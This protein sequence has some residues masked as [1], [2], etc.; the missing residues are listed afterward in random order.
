MA[1]VALITGCAVRIGRAIAQHLADS[2]WDV[3]LHY[4]TSGQAIIDCEN[5]LKRTYPDQ[6]FFT[7]Q[8]DFSDS[9]QTSLLIKLVLDRFGRL[10]LLVNNAS[11]FKA[12]SLKETTTKLFREQLQINTVAPF[13]LIRE[14]ANQ[15][16][17]GQIINIVDS[18]ITSNKSEHLSYSLSKK[19]L[20]ELTKMAALELA[21]KF[22]VNAIAPGAILS[23]AGKD[24]LYLGSQQSD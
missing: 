3:A 12:G 21:P 11:V 18:R 9:E 17:K 16:L 2:G 19:S 24:Q 7:F 5:D 6:R 20:W 8:A 1:R 10:D 14:Y 4:S 22:R 23:P 13:I 15:S